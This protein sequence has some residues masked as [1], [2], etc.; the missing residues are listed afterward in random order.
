MPKYSIIVP[1]Y[2]VEA[3]LPACIDSVLAQT[4][5]ASFELILVDDGSP[6]NS[7]RICDEY[8]ANDPRIRVLHTENR[9]VSRARNLGI[10]EACG[11]YLLFLD[12]DDVWDT[13]LLASLDSIT[14]S[15]PDMALFGFS[16]LMDDGTIFPGTLPCIPNG[17]TGPEY[18]DRLFSI[19]KVPCTYSC[20]YAYRR[21]FFL[22]NDLQYREDLIVSEDFD[23]IMRALSH[24][25]Q[26]TGCDAP[27]YRYRMREGSAS[28][29]I[30]GK[31]LMDNLTTKAQYFRQ[32]PVSAMANLYANNA[33][34][35]G[36]TERSVY[37]SAGAFLK[38]NRD[39]WKLVSEPPLKI[40]RMLIFCLGN[41]TGARLFRLLQQIHRLIRCSKQV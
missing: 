10:R 24:A 27:L 20:C 9:G 8:A 13:A 3:Y 15:T 32:Y 17:E 37:L 25:E 41:R 12:A 33:L 19:R 18:L 2:R 29:R 40:A 38:E 28:R 31:K 26:I 1:V 22:A 11:E 23:Q 34:L 7:G 39:I 5:A 21:C 16:R 35:V 36:K 14:V 30:T 4:S 6:D